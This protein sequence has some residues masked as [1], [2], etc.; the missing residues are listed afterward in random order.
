[1]LSVLDGFQSG[2]P[3]ADQVLWVQCK[4]GP[5]N[6]EEWNSRLKQVRIR[7]SPRR[8]V[9]TALPT[10]IVTPSPVCRS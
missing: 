1:M 9:R 5:T 10:Q 7:P 8:T 4:A 3:A 6:K 2:N